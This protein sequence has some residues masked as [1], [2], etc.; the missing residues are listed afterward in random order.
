MTEWVSTEHLD[1]SWQHCGRPAYWEGEQVVC[2]KC[3]TELEEG[4]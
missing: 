2:S 4:N 1:I 3:Q